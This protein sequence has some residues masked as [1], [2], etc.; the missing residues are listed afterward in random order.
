MAELDGGRVATVFTA[1]TAVQMAVC[2][3]AERNCHLHEFADANGVK[4][5]K[6]IGFVNLCLIVT[7]Q[8]L[9]CVVTAEAER[10]LS[11]VVRAEA[12]EVCFRCDFVCGECRSG[13]FN[14]RAD[15]V[16]EVNSTLFDDCVCGFDN[17]LL[18]VFQFF[19]FADER[20]HDFGHNRP[21]GMTFLNVDSRFDDRF[22]LHNGDFGI[23][24]CQTASSVTHHRVELV[25]TVAENLD[26]GHGFAFCFCK[27]FD[28]LFFGGNELVKRRIQETNGNRHA[29]E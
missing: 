7:G 18:A 5:C 9:A 15:F 20:D 14:H 26:F 8:E 22:G 19:D 10:H 25:Q 6:R 11:E 1:D 23:G 13:D 29:F 28:I 2:A 16:F 12:E 17:R 4:T 24:D 27:C 3:S 21:I